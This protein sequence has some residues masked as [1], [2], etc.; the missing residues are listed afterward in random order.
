[1]EQISFLH[2][3]HENSYQPTLYK[4]PVGIIAHGRGSEDWA[5][6]PYKTM[7]LDAIENALQTIM[8]D[9]VGIDNKSPNGVVF[10][11]KEVLKKENDIFLVQLYDWTDIENRLTLLV[12]K[13][14]AKADKKAQG[15][16]L[17]DSQYRL[18]V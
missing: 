8:M 4:K 1:M 14:I 11:V 17:L 15:N 16:R 3:F 6:R 18:S 10:P 9:V 2:W 7:V 13:L 12:E 5:M